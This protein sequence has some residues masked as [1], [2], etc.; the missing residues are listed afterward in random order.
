MLRL[1]NTDNEEKIHKVQL[2]HIH[3]DSTPYDDVNKQTDDAEK[4][5]RHK[6]NSIHIV[7]NKP[8]SAFDENLLCH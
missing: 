8:M 3:F 7:R 2:Y 1:Q 5:H 4:T 6:L